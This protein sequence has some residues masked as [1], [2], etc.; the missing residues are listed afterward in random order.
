M[1]YSKTAIV[2]GSS[3]GIGRAIAL[4]L[5]DDGY[6]V[7]VND[8]AANEKGCQDVAKEIQGK[9]RKACV[10]IADVTKRSEV[11]NMIQT[12]V[13]ELGDLNTMYG[14]IIENKGCIYSIRHADVSQGRQR[15]NSPSQSPPRL[16]RRRL[17]PH[18]RRQRQRRAE[19][20]RRGRQTTHQTRQLHQRRSREADRGLSIRSTA[21][22]QLLTPGNTG[23]VDR[24]LQAFPFAFALFGNEVGC[25]RSDTGIRNGD[26]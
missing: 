26:G 9:G 15:G 21:Y 13:K 22:R 5:A 7:T 12:S 8:I 4:R 11:A 17:Q 25:P 2:T 6:D 14:L 16:D 10:A 23:R 24:S 1:F 20:L 18:V 19:L 3:R